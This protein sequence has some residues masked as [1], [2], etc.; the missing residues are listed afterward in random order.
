[1]ALKS[2]IGKSDWHHALDAFM[3]FFPDARSFSAVAFYKR[4]AAD[5]DAVKLE[6]FPSAAHRTALIGILLISSR[7]FQQSF[8]TLRQQLSI[9][10]ALSSH[11]LAL[12]PEQR[13]DVILPFLSCSPTISSAHNV[14]AAFRRA[15]EIQDPDVV[16]A[17]G[18]ALLS[19]VEGDRDPAC[20]VQG[21][22]VTG[23]L[24][25]PKYF[26]DFL[27]R[28]IKRD[29]AMD[30][31]WTLLV[32][33][34]EKVQRRLQ[35]LRLLP[36]TGRSASSTEFNALRQSLATIEHFVARRT[37]PDRHL[38]VFVSLL[39]AYQLAELHKDVW[40]MWDRLDV[41]KRAAGSDRAALESACIS[42]RPSPSRA[43]TIEWNRLILKWAVV[44]Q[45]VRLGQGHGTSSS[46]LVGGHRERAPRLC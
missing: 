23:S 19:F 25:K 17:V 1:M 43:R 34:I 21:R 44:L 9:L 20:A 22:S 30:A 27:D 39:K 2:E 29:S 45:R 40:R 37:T 3:R 31:P 16:L 33:L 26:L 18:H 11:P 28:L 46:G 36:R 15:G 42:V 8:V 38:P 7:T 32:G 6:P 4:L 13:L 41:V 12:P 10:F 24:E 14:A 35:T 5:D